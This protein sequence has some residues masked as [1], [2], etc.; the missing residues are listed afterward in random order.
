MAGASTVQPDWAPVA[1]RIRVEATDNWDD[2]VAADRF[3]GLGGLLFRGHGTI[4]A[5]GRVAVGDD[6]L[7][8]ARG[9]VIAHRHRR[10]RSRRFPAWPARRSGPTTRS[11]RP[12][13]C[14]SR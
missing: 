14:R 6:V 2:T 3:T 13:R 10:P 9:I 12:S 5:P 4:T 7:H 8:A 11:S 1:K